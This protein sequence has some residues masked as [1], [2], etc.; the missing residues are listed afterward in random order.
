MSHWL[1]GKSLCPIDWDHSFHTDIPT[2]ELAGLLSGSLP[3]DIHKVHK[4]RKFYSGPSPPT[5]VLSP[6]YS[7]THCFDGHPCAGEAIGYATGTSCPP[8]LFG[9]KAFWRV[10]AK[11]GLCHYSAKEYPSFTVATLKAAV[12]LSYLPFPF[13]RLLLHAHMQSQAGSW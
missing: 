5:C 11:P 8:W 7:E 9:I 10:S 2:Q 6:L 4:F 12:C 1:T 13:S 3:R